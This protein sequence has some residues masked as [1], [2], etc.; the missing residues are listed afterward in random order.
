M[1]LGVKMHGGYVRD[2]GTVTPFKERGGK[3]TGR[4]RRY[5]REWEGEMLRQRARG[6]IKRR[7]WERVARWEDAGRVKVHRPQTGSEISWA[8]IMESQMHYLYIRRLYL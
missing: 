5:S 1:L 3:K 6:Y 7:E 8:T 4:K 2:G